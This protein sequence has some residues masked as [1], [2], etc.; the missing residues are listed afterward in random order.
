M[1]FEVAA[2]E[3]TGPRDHDPVVG[4]DLDAGRAQVAEERLAAQI[5]LAADRIDRQP[6]LDARRD[7]GGQR[8]E[9]HRPDVTRLVAVDEQMDVIRGRRDVLE[10]PREVAPAV[11]QGIDRGRDRRREGQG[12]V[13]APD[14]RPR[15]EL[16][17]P[18]SRPSPRGWRSGRTGRSGR[19]ACPCAGAPRRPRPRARHRSR[20]SACGSSI[21]GSWHGRVGHGAESSRRRR[22]DRASTAVADI[23]R[24]YC[25]AR[26]GRRRRASGVSLRSTET[27]TEEDIRCLSSPSRRSACRS[28]ICPRSSATR[29]SARS[30]RFACRRSTSLPSNARGSC[31]PIRSDGSTGARSTSAAP[32]PGPPR[33]PGSVARSRVDRAGRTSPARWSSSGR[34]ARSSWRTPRSASVPGERSVTC[35]PGST[36]EPVR[37]R[38]SR[39]TLTPS[40]SVEAVD[41]SVEVLEPTIPIARHRRG[42]GRRRRAG[43]DPARRGS[44]PDGRRGGGRRDAAKTDDGANGSS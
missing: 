11:E 14:A 31:C 9:E 38:A 33:S 25:S 28:S 19:V 17:G 1:R 42:G 37:A 36:S 20:S 7:L 26:G 32:S 8:V 12:Q 15:D 4:D 35:G 16:G 39:S 27:R 24:G 5:D 3:L 34:R 41:A 13:R 30:P 22:R 29:S 44:D 43:R 21:E 18:G 23:G 6:D 2:A 10:D 40:P